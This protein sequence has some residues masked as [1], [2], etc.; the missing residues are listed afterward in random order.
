[1]KILKVRSS[2]SKD[3]EGYH[4]DCSWMKMYILTVIAGKRHG[5]SQ[6]YFFFDSEQC[7]SC[8]SIQCLPFIILLLAFRLFLVRLPCALCLG[9]KLHYFCVQEVLRPG[10]TLINCLIA[11]C[12]SVLLGLCYL[13]DSNSCP[14]HSHAEALFKMR[15]TLS[16]TLSM[17]FSARIIALFE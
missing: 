9:I 7:W 1:M 5:N 8:I 6:N 12:G 11:L 2:K 10:N 4:G 3:Y 14:V 13:C 17:L 15:S 16:L